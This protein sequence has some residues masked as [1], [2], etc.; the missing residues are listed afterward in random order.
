MHQEK[1]NQEHSPLKVLVMLPFLLHSLPILQL[2]IQGHCR[3]LCWMLIFW[4][5]KMSY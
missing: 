2:V 1:H 3:F 4:A 5:V